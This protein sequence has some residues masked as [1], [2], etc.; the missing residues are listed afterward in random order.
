MPSTAFISAS[1]GGIVFVY[2][3]ERR[4][5]WMGLRDRIA[6]AEQFEG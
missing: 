2:A 3:G 4:G 1:R 6:S 5:P